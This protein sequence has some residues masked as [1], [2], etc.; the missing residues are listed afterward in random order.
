MPFITPEPTQVAKNDLCPEAPIVVSIAGSDPSAGAGIQADLKTFAALNVYGMSIIS[1]LTA[2]NYREVSALEAVSPQMFE[3][4]FRS[5]FDAY[6]VAAVKIGMIGDARI[7]ERLATLLQQYQPENVVF[8]P[9]MRS[10]SGA[11]L[12]ASEFSARDLLAPLFPFVDLLTPNIPEACALLGRSLPSDGA[13]ESLSAALDQLQIKSILLKG[14]HGSNPDICTDVLRSADKETSY[15][16]P[17][18]HTPHLHGTG[19]TLSSAIASF[20]AR[21]FKLEQA[22]EH[23]IAFTHQTIIHSGRMRIA[24]FNGPLCHFYQSLISHNPCDGN[25]TLSN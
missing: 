11:E 17:R 15:C 19:C 25:L 6:P 13:L 3:A 21:D 7:I 22:V 18:I 23:A 24:P 8:D 12:T 16:H 5:I 20:L 9:V 4:Q 14:G 1:I 10:S 2:Q